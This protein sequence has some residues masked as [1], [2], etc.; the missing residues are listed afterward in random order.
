MRNK[1]LIGNKILRV[2]RYLKNISYN[3]NR[4]ERNEAQ[5]TIKE[6]LEKLEEITTLLNT[7]T[8]DR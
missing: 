1:N 6:T 7:E 2:E 5:A 8:Q 4:N 3:I